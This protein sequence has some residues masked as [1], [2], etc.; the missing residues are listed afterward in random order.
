MTKTCNKYSEKQRHV[1]KTIA[2]FYN[3]EYKDA[4]KFVYNPWDIKHDIKH[5]DIKIKSI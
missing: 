1:A 3:I 2:L 4:L 5:G